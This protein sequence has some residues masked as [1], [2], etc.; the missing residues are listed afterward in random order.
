M[1]IPTL[2]AMTAL[3]DSAPKAVSAADT[4]GYPVSCRTT[5]PDEA[6]VD[7]ICWHPDELE[8]FLAEKVGLKAGPG[9]VQLASC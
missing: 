2:T 7:K 4:I 6:V 5:V 3:E 9:I 1:I 8:D